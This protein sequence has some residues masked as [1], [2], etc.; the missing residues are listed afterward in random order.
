M[1]HRMQ[2]VLLGIG[3]LGA[4]C[5]L[6]H[7]SNPN[8]REPDDASVADGD[9]DM[10]AGSDA[11][12]PQDAETDAARD[13]A[14]RDSGCACTAPDSL[15]C[16]AAGACVECT[17]ADRR[18]CV[19][20]KSVCG[21]S[22]VCV[23]CTESEKTACATPMPACDP[24]THLCVA[25]NMDPECAE[26]TPVCTAQHTCEKCSQDAHCKRFGKVCDEAAGSC[27]ACTIDSEALQCGNNSCNPATKQCTLT[28]RASV[29]QCQACVADSECE[30]NHRCLEMFFG[31][32]AARMS[33]SGR[34]MKRSSTGCALPYGGAP[35]SRQ[36]LSGAPAENYCGIS[37]ARTSCEAIRKL[38]QGAGCS[39]GND[40]ACAAPGAL[41]RTVNSISNICSYACENNLECPMN[42]A[43]PATGA[44]KH[45]GKN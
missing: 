44:D 29:A 45:C 5:D 24:Q 20:N 25:C 3:L 12:A 39:A 15:V 18:A 31:T 13:S 21:P 23:Q 22:N 2:R 43:C 42:A 40:S 26:T 34:C 16:T 19:G 37:E 33:L 11:D 41:C 17:A 36:S 14:V 7:G 30:T 1:K 32:G 38:Q 6:Q 10:D 27:V 28:P 9:A 4:A 35:I 8:Y